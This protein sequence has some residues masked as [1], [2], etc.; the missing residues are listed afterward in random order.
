MKNHNGLTRKIS[1]LEYATG[2]SGD[3]Y[4]KIMNMALHPELTREP[5]KEELETLTEGVRKFFDFV[6][7]TYTG[8]VESEE[9]K[10]LTGI[11]PETSYQAPELLKSKLS[12]YTRHIPRIAQKYNLSVPLD[13][14]EAVRAKYNFPD[15]KP[16]SLNY[17]K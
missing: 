1:A 9:G 14:I 6:L 5:T 13:K 4:S 10:V 16:Y 3:E 17:Q 2:I 7:K 12:H 11:D 8:E 15:E